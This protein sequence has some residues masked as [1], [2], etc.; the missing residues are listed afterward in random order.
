MTGKPRGKVAMTA[1]E[2]Q[3]RW[4]AKK[5]RQ[6]IFNANRDP[7]ARRPTP[8]RKDFDFWPT[9]TELRAALIEAVLPTLP[10]GPVWECAAGDGILVDALRSAGR[11][12]I[13]IGRAHV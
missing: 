3:R 4:R 13:E 8:Q 10:S 1:T 2:R 9:P 6:A 7:A 5:R 11:E 12:V